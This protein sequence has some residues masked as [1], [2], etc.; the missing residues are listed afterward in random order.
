MRHRSSLFVAIALVMLAACAGVPVDGPK[1]IVAHLDPLAGSG[2]S[3]SA[4]FV[5]TTS[6]VLVTVDATGL[7]RG[8]HGIDIYESGDCANAVKRDAV[9]LEPP[10]R[11]GGRLPGM[12][13]YADRLPPLM[14]QAGG[15]ARLSALVWGYAFR[16]NVAGIIGRAV[17]VRAGIDDPYG[18]AGSPLACGVIGPATR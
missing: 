13:V 18:T 6:G 11:I 17:V 3:G 1:S 15:N 12:D 5:E 2:V 4:E 14:A 8:R 9:R 10:Q 7:P 16:G